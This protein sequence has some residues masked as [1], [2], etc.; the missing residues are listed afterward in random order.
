MRIAGITKDSVVNGIGIRDVIFVQ[1]CGHHCEGCH[2][3]QTWD[4]NGG[5][6]MEVDDLVNFL[7]DSPNQVTISGGEPLNQFN[8]VYELMKRVNE[9]SGKRFW[10][11]VKE[12]S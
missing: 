9:S 8:D 4:F 12:R 7:K 5:L 2:N 1:G 10:V 11:Y 3:P 6:H